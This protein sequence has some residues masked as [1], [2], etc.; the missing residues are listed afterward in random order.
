[1]Y[2]LHGGMPE[3]VVSIV[4]ILIVQSCPNFFVCSNLYS[5]EISKQ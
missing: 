2:A 3:E 1:M 5:I 4:H